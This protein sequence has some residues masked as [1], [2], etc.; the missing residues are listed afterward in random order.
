MKYRIEYIAPGEEEQVVIRCHRRTPETDRI[1]AAATGREQ[2]LYCPGEAGGVLLGKREII[3]IESVDGKTYAC[4]EKDTLRLSRSLAAL[5]RQ[6]GEINFFRCSKSMII[7]IN[8]IKELKSLS[9]NRIDATM[10]T[11]EHIIISRTY[12]SELRRILR[13]EDYE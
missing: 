9:S 2:K 4:T 3:Y 6:L 1:I 10:C 12:A 5:E 13:G 8:C 11:G 7:N